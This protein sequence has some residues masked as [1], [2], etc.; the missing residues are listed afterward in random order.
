MAG[1]AETSSG[2]FVF[3]WVQYGGLRYRVHPAQVVEPAEIP[4]C[5]RAHGSI[6]DCQC[7]QDRIAH[8]CS[9]RTALGHETFQQLCVTRPRMKDNN[10]RLSQPFANMSKCHYGRHRRRPHPGIGAEAHKSPERTPRQA[11][12]VISGEQFLQP[13]SSRL[14]AWESSSEA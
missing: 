14:L 11:N 6:L 10:T 9:C 13:G 4:V 1:R 8:Q 2:R 3:W 12:R 7:S 5:G